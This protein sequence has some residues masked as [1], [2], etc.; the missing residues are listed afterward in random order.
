MSDAL[1]RM[2]EEAYDKELAAMRRGDDD[3]ARMVRSHITRLE[4]LLVRRG[5][6]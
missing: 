5:E 1:Y 6:Q 3:T 4:T 2:L